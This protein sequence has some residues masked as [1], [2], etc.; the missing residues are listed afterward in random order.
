MRKTRAWELQ[1]SKW[2]SHPM[3]KTNGMWSKKDMG[4][5]EAGKRCEGTKEIRKNGKMA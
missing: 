2:I 3:E 5:R 1:E 4:E